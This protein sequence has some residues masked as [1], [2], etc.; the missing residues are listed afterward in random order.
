[1]AMSP[2]AVE[3]PTAVAYKG[4]RYH[5]FLSI[6]GS[7][8]ACPQRLL[9]STPTAVTNGNLSFQAKRGYLFVLNFFRRKGGSDDAQTGGGCF[10]NANERDGSSTK[11]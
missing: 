6:L 9:N 1:G 8:R 11:I 7:V 4:R 2:T 10:F 3:F 5:R